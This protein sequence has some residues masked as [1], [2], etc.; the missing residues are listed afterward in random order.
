MKEPALLQKKKDGEGKKV[1][2][3][4][5]FLSPRCLSPPENS[6]EFCAI[7]NNTEPRTPRSV[8]D[9]SSWKKRPQLLSEPYPSSLATGVFQKFTFEVQ[10][11]FPASKIL[12]C[13][14]LFKICACFLRLFF[15]VN[16]LQNY[17][18]KFTQRESWVI[19]GLNN[20]FCE[21]NR[22]AFC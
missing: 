10:F 22:G 20:I 7:T 8:R 12:L 9:N 14:N 4:T 19:F 3:H 6:G 16:C 15:F 18:K 2:S 17:S 1:H 21:I 5:L 11:T 13:I